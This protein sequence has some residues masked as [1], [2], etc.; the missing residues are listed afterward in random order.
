MQGI[1]TPY[2]HVDISLVNSTKYMYVPCRLEF[3]L[4]MQSGDLKR[5]LQTLIVL[6][7][8][9]SIGQ[10]I[11]LSADGIGVLSLTATQEAKAEAV[12]GVV[13][14][15]SEFLDLIDAADATAQG[16]IAGQ[17]L[18]RLA[19][20]GAVEGALQPNELRRLS[21]RLATHG[22]LTRLAVIAHSELHV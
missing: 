12:F 9:R 4:A 14:F 15:A 5:A 13:K 10:D 3:D 6:S 17:A 21:L 8:S 7:N 11:E 22:E 1:I 20:A 19:A 16:D 18:K 2:F